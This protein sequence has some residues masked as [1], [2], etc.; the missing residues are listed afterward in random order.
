MLKCQTPCIYYHE[1]HNKQ[2]KPSV[3]VICDYR[4]GEEIKNIPLEEINNCDHFTTLTEVKQKFK[5][6]LRNISK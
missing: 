1:I 6:N 5:N 3:K 2:E 4:E